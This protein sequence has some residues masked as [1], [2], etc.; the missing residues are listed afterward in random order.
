M[1][2]Q[3]R[4]S[5]EPDTAAVRARA[6]SELQL[7][8]GEVPTL[9]PA[10]TVHGVQV[11]C[12]L[13]KGRPLWVQRSATNSSI[14]RLLLCVAR[15]KSDSQFAS[16]RTGASL[17]IPLKCRRPSSNIGNLAQ[18]REDPQPDP[19]TSL[20]PARLIGVDDGAGPQRLHQGI[21][22][23]LGTPG[24]TLHGHDTMWSA[25]RGNPASARIPGGSCR[26]TPRRSSSGTRRRRA[27]WARNAPCPP[28]TPSKSAADAGHGHA[29]HTPGSGHD[30]LRTSRSRVG[31]AECRPG[32]DRCSL[33]LLPYLRTGTAPGTEPRRSCR[34]LGR[35]DGLP[36]VLRPRLASGL[37]RVPFRLVLGEG[38][39][40]ALAS[41]P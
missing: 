26:T 1:A 20:L 22:G 34:E 12:A 37:L 24:K 13:S 3:P 36:P 25:P 18:V 16:V 33:P 30:P 6:E 21:S 19:T 4:A 39:G 8:P 9:A 29:D 10:W 2:P 38:C 40:L 28:R 35:S 5:P 41:A 31:W 17:A 27:A 14:F 11:A 23:G 32:T 15:S 7:R